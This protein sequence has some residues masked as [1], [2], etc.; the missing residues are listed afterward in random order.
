MQEKWWQAA[1][2]TFLELLKDS[3]I[4]Q[5]TLAL[6]ITFTIIYMTCIGHGDQLS[7]EFWVVAGAIFGFYFKS[8]NDIQVRRIAQDA[9][10][11]RQQSTGS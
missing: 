7:K 2:S 1:I 4:I 5:G 11:I 6:G 3:V 8:K 10:A 9:E